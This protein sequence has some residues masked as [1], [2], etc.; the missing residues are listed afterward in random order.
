[1]KT[2]RPLYLKWLIAWCPALAG[3]AAVVLTNAQLLDGMFGVHNNQS[4]QN[5]LI[6]ITIVLLLVGWI[7]GLIFTLNFLRKD[8]LKLRAGAILLALVAVFFLPVAVAIVLQIPPA[9]DMSKCRDP[10]P[11]ANLFCEERS[12]GW[13]TSL[14]RSHVY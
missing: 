3:A 6:N 13:L 8:E 14:K 2:Y 5:S 11:P 10:H 1:M 12:P 4:W 7:L 9:V